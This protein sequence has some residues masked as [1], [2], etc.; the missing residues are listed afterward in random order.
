MP[1]LATV[2]KQHPGNQGGKVPSLLTNIEEETLADNRRSTQ[3]NN[4]TS[5][6]KNRKSSKGISLKE[7]RAP[8][9]KPEARLIQPGDPEVKVMFQQLRDQLDE[10]G[11]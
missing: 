11:K 6:S 3:S 10:T 2:L 1:I 8:N 5:R 4:G 9:G 7:S